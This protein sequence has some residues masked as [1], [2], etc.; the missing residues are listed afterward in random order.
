MIYKENGDL[1][2]FGGNQCGQ[3]GLGDKNNKNT[4]TFL[5]NDL[6]IEDIVCGNEH[7]IYC[8]KNGEIFVLG[9]NNNKRLGFDNNGQI[10][11]PTLLMKIE[12]RKM[13]RT[14]YH[15]LILKKDGEIIGFGSN[16]YNKISEKISGRESLSPQIIMKDETIQYFDCL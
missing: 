1:L 8:K 10:E 16:Y 4:A 12:N 11:I 3:L 9:K 14:S 13:I 15:T 7:T 5:L 6:D 2:V